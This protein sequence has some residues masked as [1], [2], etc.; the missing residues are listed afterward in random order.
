MQ[1]DIERFLKGNKQKSLPN[2]GWIQPC[3][4]CN[5]PTARIFNYLYNHKIYKCYFCKDC[6]SDT[7]N[8]ELYA[9]NILIKIYN[10]I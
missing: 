2:N 1:K 6:I 10:Y 5:A 4:N 7:K 3:L 8:I 9:K